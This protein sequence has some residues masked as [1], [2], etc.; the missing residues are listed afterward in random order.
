MNETLH[1]KPANAARPRAAGGLHYLRKP[2]KK[3]KK[4]QEVAA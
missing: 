4:L 2:L 3:G 1:A